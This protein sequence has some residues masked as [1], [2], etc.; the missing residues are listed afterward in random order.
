M[1]LSWFGIAGKLMLLSLTAASPG[2]FM[3]QRPHFSV[4]RLI[5]CSIASGSERLETAQIVISGVHYGPSIQWNFVNLLKRMRSMSV[6]MMGYSRY[7][8]WETQWEDMSFKL[9]LSF[10]ALLGM[11]RVNTLASSVGKLVACI[12]NCSQW[13]GRWSDGGDFSVCFYMLLYNLI[14]F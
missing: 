11:T 8:Q 5:Q 4:T 10:I 14:F 1:S 13:V 3:S 2:T 7:I 6:H 9:M 12:I